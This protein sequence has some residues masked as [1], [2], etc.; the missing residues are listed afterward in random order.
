MPISAVTVVLAYT[1]AALYIV[2]QCF[3][4][5]IECPKADVKPRTH[6]E[7]VKVGLYSCDFPFPTL[8]L[9]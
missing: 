7:V 8:P 4:S 3:V 1:L 2:I 5:L 6:S 9:P